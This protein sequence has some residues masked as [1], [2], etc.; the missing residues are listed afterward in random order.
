MALVKALDDDADEVRE[1]AADT[2]SFILSES[3][4][5][6][7]SN[8]SR[9]SAWQCEPVT[10]KHLLVEE[11]FQRFDEVLVQHA[12]FAILGSSLPYSSIKPDEVPTKDISSHFHPEE[13]AAT[14]LK[15]AING[16]E[17]ILFEEERPNIYIDEV[18]KAELFA[19]MLLKYPQYLSNDAK[20][21]QSLQDWLVPGLTAIATYTE[22]HRATALPIPAA[23]EVFV[24]GL[25]FFVLADVLI[26]ACVT[27]PCRDGAKAHALTECLERF[28]D[29]EK[30]AGVDID[31]HWMRKI[32]QALARVDT[33]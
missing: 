18:E 26:A 16:E 12:I 1:V 22:A 6:I 27:Q 31:I 4:A 19:S 20:A 25:R 17:A 10:A 3:Q 2:V 13:P 21:V 32:R 9:V 15:Q 23:R 7:T 5:R 24:V 28:C 14:M 29:L 8:L 30:M 33:T 11:L